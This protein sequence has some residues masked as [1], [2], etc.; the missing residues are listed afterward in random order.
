PPG[1]C[2]GTCTK[3]VTTTS[4][5]TLTATGT[6]TVPSMLVGW[7]ASTGGVCSGT[8]TC[9]FGA[10]TTAQ[11]VTVT[12]NDTTGPLTS[13]PAV[14]PSPTN[15]APTVTASVSDVN[16]GSLTGSTISTAEFFIDAAGANGTGTAM[17]ASDGAFNSTTEGVTKALSS[18]QF[19]AL[20]EG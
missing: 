9:T 7:S 6:G 15:A 2:T 18:V 13:S 14:S 1:A 4:A 20:T 16:Q 3:N 8:G 17:N 5:V 19:S 12:F 11:T 10:S